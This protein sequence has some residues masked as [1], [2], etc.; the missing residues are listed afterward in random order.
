VSSASFVN[1][2]PRFLSVIVIPW[3]FPLSSSCMFG[4]FPLRFFKSSSSG[5]LPEDLAVPPAGYLDPPLAI[6]SP[7]EQGFPRNVFLPVSLFLFRLFVFAVVSPS[8]IFV[9]FLYIA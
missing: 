5:E 2:P 4:V 8:M 9:F 3:F 1:Q 6:F 7:M